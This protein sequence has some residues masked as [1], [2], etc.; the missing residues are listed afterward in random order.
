M[1]TTT[2]DS[3]VVVA[4][5]SQRAAG[6]DD[7]DEGMLP[8]MITEQLMLSLSSDSIEVSGASWFAG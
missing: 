6:T 8:V 2:G 7:S 5:I 1:T 4:T 3:A